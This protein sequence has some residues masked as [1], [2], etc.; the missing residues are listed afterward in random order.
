M[1]VRTLLLLILLF[2][3]ARAAW[4]LLEGVVRGAQESVHG[5]RRSPATPPPAPSVKMARDPVC[6]T[7][8]VPG[9]ALSLTDGSAVLYFCSEECRSRYKAR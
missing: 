2:F 5:G 9:K 6:G 3:L 4:R 8:V 7:F 1:L